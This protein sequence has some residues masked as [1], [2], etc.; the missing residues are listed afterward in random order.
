MLAKRRIHVLMSVFLA[1]VLFVVTAEHASAAE[2]DTVK[3]Y[4]NHNT[5]VYN[6]KGKRLYGK[7]NYIKKNIVI[8]APGKLEKTNSVKRYYIM[9]RSDEGT[10]SNYKTPTFTYL[11]WLPY[12]IIKNIEYY[13]TG[14]NRYI[15]CMNV[16]AIYTEALPSPY[17]HKARLLAT[18]QETVITRDPKEINQKHIYALTKVANNRVEDAIILPKNKKLVVDDTVGFDNLI[19][20]AY[21]IKNTNYY[22]KAFDVVRKPRHLV[23]SH[24]LKSFVDGITTVY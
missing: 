17:S 11:Y 4:L 24:P 23:F 8:T 15:K 12:T 13:K 9:K 10:V 19:G 5:Y 6:N 14:P 2:S 22:V 1:A 3:L 18:N 21:H 7:G 16:K 20:T